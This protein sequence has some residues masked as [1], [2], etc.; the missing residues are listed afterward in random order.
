MEPLSEFYLVLNSQRQV[1]ATHSRPGPQGE[2]HELQ[3]LCLDY[4][5]QIGVEGFKDYEDH[6]MWVVNGEWYTDNQIN[7]MLRLKVFA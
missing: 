5:K 7:R 2:D 1:I 4:F 3:L 6:T